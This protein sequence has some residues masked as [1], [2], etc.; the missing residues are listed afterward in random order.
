MLEVANQSADCSW[1]E[2]DCDTI[3]RR[4][5][6]LAARSLLRDPLADVSRAAL[7]FNAVGFGLCQKLHSLTVDHLYFCKC[8]SGNVVSVELSANNLQVFRREPTADAKQ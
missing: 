5:C 7:E 8:N 6:A 4:L 3:Y 1:V 2:R